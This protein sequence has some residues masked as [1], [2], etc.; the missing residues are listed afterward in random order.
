VDGLPE[1]QGRCI[2]LAGLGEK[3]FRIIWNHDV[4]SYS[5]SGTLTHCR[6]GETTEDAK[7]QET[8]LNVICER[9]DGNTVEFS[10]S[11][12]AL[13]QVAS[14]PRWAVHIGHTAPIPHRRIGDTGTTTGGYKS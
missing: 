10:G 14:A 2:R 4:R 1:V 12:N 11:L 3:A 8:I 5:L 13:N 6:I 7:R 9:S